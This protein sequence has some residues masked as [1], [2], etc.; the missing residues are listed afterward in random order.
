MTSPHLSQ[1]EEHLGT[2]YDLV[3]VAAKRAQQIKDGARPL[4]EVNSNNPLTIA[5]RE[6]AEG[7]VIVKPY[8][9]ADEPE[10]QPQ[11]PERHYL[12]QRG[13]LAKVMTNSETDEP[14]PQDD[15]SEE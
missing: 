8:D 15:E 11:R 4:V 10:Q 1:L 14:E 9:Q 12:S 2:S 13:A 5:L 3:V 7:K 6:I